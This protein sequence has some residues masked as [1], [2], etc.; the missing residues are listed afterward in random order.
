MPSVILG[1]NS[2]VELSK[3]FLKMVF[4]A[5]LL[6]AQHMEWCGEQASKLACCVLGQGTKRDAS[7]FMW[8]TGGG[9]K[10]TRRG[11]PV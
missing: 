7:I 3:R 6:G 11:G 1:F 5:F 2:Q 9:A 8:Q 4:T 10:S